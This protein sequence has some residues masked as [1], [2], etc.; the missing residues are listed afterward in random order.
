V[1]LGSV[2]SLFRGLGISS[3]KADIERAKIERRREVVE[4]T[5]RKLEA[6]RAAEPESLL[7]ERKGV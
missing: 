7:R 6:L 5:L 1:A 2:F 4:T 3:V